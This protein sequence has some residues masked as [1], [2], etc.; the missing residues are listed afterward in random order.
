V[1][2]QLTDFAA[3]AGLQEKACFSNTR[4]RFQETEKFLNDFL[5][6]FFHPRVVAASVHEWNN[7]IGINFKDFTV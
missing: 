1:A 7:Q 2:K 3:E 6:V 5:V 4:N